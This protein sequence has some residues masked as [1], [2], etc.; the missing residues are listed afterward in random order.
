[1]ACKRSAVRSRL[2][3][4]LLSYLYFLFTFLCSISYA[5]E[6]PVLLSF[7]QDR[8]RFALCPPACISEYI[9]GPILA[10]VAPSQWE[11][12]LAV[13]AID[14]SWRNGGNPESHDVLTA[15]TDVG[16]SAH[17]GAEYR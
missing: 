1:M 11:T 4:P 13:S 12:V 5:P 10:S 14:S 7:V 9:T 15:A 6:Y 8:R 3:P 16:I 17:D 2:A